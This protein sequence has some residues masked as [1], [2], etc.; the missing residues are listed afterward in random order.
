[1]YYLLRCDDCGERLNRIV[2]NDPDELL[3]P[4]D[5]ERAKEEAG[6]LN[7]EALEDFHAAHRGHALSVHP[8]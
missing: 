1:M 2:A 5:W 4:W 3:H 7:A 8:T 6:E